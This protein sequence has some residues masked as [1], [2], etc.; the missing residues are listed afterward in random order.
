MFAYPCELESLLPKLFAWPG[1]RG[2]LFPSPTS[3]QMY[4]Y[5][6]TN[7]PLQM[8]TSGNMEGILVAR[9]R[10]SSVRSNT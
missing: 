3:I 9:A 10:G 5:L 7:C 6:Q 4:A 1:Q 8:H 2:L